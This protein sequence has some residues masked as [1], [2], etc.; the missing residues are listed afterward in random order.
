MDHA[1]R[2]MSA[3]EYVSKYMCGGNAADAF[4]VYEV[5]EQGEGEGRNLENDIAM[6]AR[7]L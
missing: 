7:F 3:G 1:D 2:T 5:G 4:T 6:R